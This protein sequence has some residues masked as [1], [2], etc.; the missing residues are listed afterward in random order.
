MV[1]PVTGSMLSLG[2]PRW[3]ELTQAY[4]TAEDVPRLLETLTHIG[5]EEARAEVWFAL[6]RMLLRQ[7]TVYTASYGAVPH[8]LGIGGVF[9]LREQAEAVHLVTRIEVSRRAPESAPM[10]SDLVDAY[11]VAVDSLPALVA[12]IATEPWPP[13]VAQ[14]FAAALLAGKRQPEV[15]LGLLELGHALTCPTCGTSYLATPS[16]D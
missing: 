5:R 8:L 3:G 13:D 14:V 12:S 15:A 6:W 11:A 16:S 9:G 1:A 2:S 4:G 10:P 7:G